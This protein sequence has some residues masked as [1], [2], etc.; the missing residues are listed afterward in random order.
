MMRESGLLGFLQIV[1]VTVR[2]GYSTARAWQV[3]AV[4]ALIAALPIALIVGIVLLIT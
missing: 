4:F 1:F 3:M 2:D